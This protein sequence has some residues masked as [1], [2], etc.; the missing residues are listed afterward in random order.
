MSFRLHGSVGR[1]L[2]EPAV[3]QAIREAH[4]R[5]LRYPA[6]FVQ[7][8]R[9]GLQN[10]GLHI[11]KH[12]KRI[13][14][15][16]ATR[17][18][19]FVPSSGAVTENISLILETITEFPLCTRKMLAERVLSKKR[20][21]K[22]RRSGRETPPARQAEPPAAVPP[23]Q[24]KAEP[25]DATPTDEPVPAAALEPAP[26]EA[27]AASETD[28]TAAVATPVPAEQPDDEASRAK[29]ALAADVRFLVQAGHIIEFHNGT[30]DLPLLPKP[31]EE[32]PKRNVAAST[33]TREDAAPDIGSDPALVSE[34]GTDFAGPDEPVTQAAVGGTRPPE[35]EPSSERAVEQPPP[36]DPA[37][38]TGARSM[39]AAASVE[40]VNGGTAPVEADP[41]EARSS[42]EQA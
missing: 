39:E 12:R 30:F 6:Q 21:D 5:E 28:G 37:P 33:Q 8:L 3:M 32:P 15:V 1:G 25:A 40:A 29:A 22:A 11:F 20:G 24:A 9:Q 10:A 38:E 34:G 4:E 16:A 14:Y 18:T 31:K 7:L 2:P 26:T 35:V 27:Q 36:M 23:T 13:V 42:E 19:P 41:A 17:P